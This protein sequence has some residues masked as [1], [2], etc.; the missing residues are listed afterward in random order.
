MTLPLEKP[1]DAITLEDV[2]QTKDGT[3]EYLDNNPATVAAHR[4]L[5][6]KL[7]MTLM[8]MIWILYL[9]NYLDRNNIS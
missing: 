7:D 8:P 6:R 2:Y 4:R 1:T 5:V 9:F 3:V